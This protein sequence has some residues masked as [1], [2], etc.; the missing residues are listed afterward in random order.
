VVHAVVKMT[1]PTLPPIRPFE[2]RGRGFIFHVARWLDR[3]DPGAHRRIK[4]LRLVTAY[5]IAAMLGTMP[6]IVRS[7]PNGAALSSLAA[8]FS[9]WASVSEGQATRLRSTCD[10]LLLNAA[11]VAGAIMVATLT[12]L[13]SGTARLGPELLLVSGG[14]LVGYLKRFGI[15]GAGIGSQI[16]IGQL[17]AFGAGLT[18]AH[19]NMIVVA[20]MIGSV[21]SI[22]PRILSGPAEHPATSPLVS[23]VSRPSQ[24]LTMGLQAAFSALVIV[25]LNGWIH[26]AESAWAITASTY[27]VAGS[28]RGTIDRVRQRI[29]GTML[30]VPLALVCLPL[31]VHAPLIIWICAALAMIVYAMALPE[32]YDVA[33]GAYAFTLLVTL[34]LTGQYSL[35]LLL[36]RAWE[37]VV[38]GLLGLAVTTFI[39]PLRTDG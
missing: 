16:F 38:G 26:L 31:V 28:A 9:L 15:R 12:P 8:G 11:S 1:Q 3:I 32:R 35:S 18:S 25:V 7:V 27:V 33:C 4:G 19:L 10:L 39:F 36:A 22:V 29:I 23:F 2:S 21:A 6:E 34:A 13:L 14:F 5:S 17:L 30:G 24:S 37:T 20:G